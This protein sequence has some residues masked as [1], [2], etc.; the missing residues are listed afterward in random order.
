[1]SAM[2][3]RLPAVGCVLLSA[4]CLT[5][6]SF[7]QTNWSRTYGGPNED[8]GEFVQQTSDGGYVVA[9][10]TSSFGAGGEDVYLIKTNTRGDT[11]WAAPDLLDTFLG[12]MC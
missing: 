2:R 3:R 9:G 4:I 5:S 11:L 1:M 8:Y 10:R 6:T 7:A 12:G